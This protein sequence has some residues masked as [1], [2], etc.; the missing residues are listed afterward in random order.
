M[1]MDTRDIIERAARS[2]VT[3]G[4]AGILLVYGAGCATTRVKPQQQIS[5][6]GKET[7]YFAPEFLFAGDHA[8]KAQNFPLCS[9]LDSVELSRSFMDMVERNADAFTRVE[10]RGARDNIDR[11]VGSAKVLAWMLT[12]ESMYETKL[13]D[14][15]WEAYLLVVGQI[16]VMD[17][18]GSGDGASPQ[19]VAAY[20]WYHNFKIPFTSPIAPDAWVQE[21]IPKYWISSTNFESRARKL[22]GQVTARNMGRNS[23]SIKNL[24]FDSK[25]M[26]SM[27]IPPQIASN[28]AS[29]EALWATL[30]SAVLVDELGV[31]MLP[32]GK[33]VATFR[34]ASRLGSSSALNFEVPDSDFGM[35]L[36]VQ[37]FKTVTNRESA[38]EI[39]RIFGVKMDVGL[40]ENF[41]DKSLY[42]ESVVWGVP[43]IRPKTYEPVF[44]ANYFT[45]LWDSLRHSVDVLYKNKEAKKVL[46]R[47]KNY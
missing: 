46:D 29:Y 16:L 31:S 34:M 27:E 32:Y 26:M 35:T 41:R 28:M 38:S 11:D 47:C 33:D 1:F 17:F 8:S 25:A 44:Y 15:L 40:R 5:K 23:L 6:L 36:D 43:Q 14:D 20:P 7:V 12:G 39:E 3:L 22:F 9:Q 19:I 30:Y 2:F 13:G 21:Y 42:K 24:S 45:A 37:G 18:E 10:F 4:V